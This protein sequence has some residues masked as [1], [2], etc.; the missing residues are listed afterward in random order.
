VGSPISA[1]SIGQVAP[2]VLRYDSGSWRVD[3]QARQAIVDAGA[4]QST[5]TGVAFASPS[6]GWLVA[7]A[8]N[9]GTASQVNGSAVNVLHFDGT[10]WKDCG[11]A[12]SSCGD[13]AGRLPLK[14][15]WVGVAPRLTSVGRRVYLYGARQQTASAGNFPLIL[16]KDPGQPWKSEEGGYDPL[17]AP[18]G[19]G[20][21]DQ[22]AVYSLSVAQAGDGSY[23]GWASGLFGGALSGKS[24]LLPGG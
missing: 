11:S 15:A 16:Y 6:D 7:Q 14:D 22:G 4:S 9:S 21:S 2:A 1:G 3:D 8:P 20:A 17:N 13:D 19:A 24:S 12:P 23:T 10:S 5:L 18:G